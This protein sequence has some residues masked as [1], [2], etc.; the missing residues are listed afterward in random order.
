VIPDYS[1]ELR[2]PATART[3]A[4]HALARLCTEETAAAIRALASGRET[5]G[6]ASVVV[7]LAVDDALRTWRANNPE[8]HTD[9]PDEEVR[10]GSIAVQIEHDAGKLGITLWPTT[11][12]MQ[13]ACVDSPTLRRALAVLLADHQGIAGY[14]DRGD[15]S[16]AEIWPKDEAPHRYEHELVRRLE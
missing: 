7:A 14:L 6:E 5:A 16:L 4:L 15:G 10:V 3:G 2:F 11:R 13:I 9:V 12:A 8:M 1:F